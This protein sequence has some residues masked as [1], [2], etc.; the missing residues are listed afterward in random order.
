[1][2]ICVYAQNWKSYFSRRSLSISRTFA[3]VGALPF[4]GWVLMK[5]AIEPAFISSAT[6]AT[7][8]ISTGMYCT[9]RAI[10]FPSSLMA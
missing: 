8:A 9:G 5:F 7:C 1:M 2:C 6:R 10:A 3:T 4:H